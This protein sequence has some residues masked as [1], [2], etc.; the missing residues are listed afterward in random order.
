MKNDSIEPMLDGEWISCSITATWTLTF[1]PVAF[2][3]RYVLQRFY[4]NI[5][6]IPWWNEGKWRK[7]RD[8]DKVKCMWITMRKQR[9]CGSLSKTART[10]IGKCEKMANRYSTRESRLMARVLV[11]S[12]LFSGILPHFCFSY[13]FNYTT[14]CRHV[15][16]QSIIPSIFIAPT[17]TDR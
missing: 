15:I 10:Q 13:D 12:A 16:L 9:F 7:E 4:L 3:E 11:G 6:L 5:P 17:D 2:T 8:Q 14:K 1:S